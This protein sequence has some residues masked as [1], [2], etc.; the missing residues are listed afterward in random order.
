[1]R[2]EYKKQILEEA[3]TILTRPDNIDSDCISLYSVAKLL[4]TLYKDHYNV[5][6]EYKTKL[7]EEMKKE[8]GWTAT[9]IIENFDYKIKELTVG[10]SI[11]GGRNY[12]MAHYNKEND[13]LQLSKAR[14]NLGKFYFKDYE[15]ILSDLYDAFL[16]FENFN[17]INFYSQNINCV[18]S[19][20]KA[21]I[22]SYRIDIFVHNDDIDRIHDYFRIEALSLGNEYNS[23]SI[24]KEVEEIFSGIENRYFKKIF[25][26]ISD[27][28]EWMQE[29]LYKIRQDQLKLKEENNN[30]MKNEKKLIKKLFSFLNK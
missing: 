4:R 6:K 2:L 21:N 30:K 3:K 19:T 23:S 15:D 20:F 1:M 8:Y 5:R 14:Y 7:D 22:Y 27:C 29:E 18:D 16:P 26:K 24:N 28:P 9:T 25:V 13:K 10:F 11:D 17:N 12:K